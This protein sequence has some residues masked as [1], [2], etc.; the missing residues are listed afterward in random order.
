MIRLSLIGRSGLVNSAD[1][2][3]HELRHEAKE[4]AQAAIEA[5]S[6]EL[7]KCQIVEADWQ[8]RVSR[9]LAAAYLLEEDPRWQSGFDGDAQLWRQAR[10]VV[11][12]AVNENGRFLDVG[13]AT[14]H[15]MECL[16]SW[17]LEKG[18]HLEMYGLEL[19]PDLAAVARR[20]LPGWADR[21]FEGNVIDWHAP[22]RFRYVRTGLEY[23]PPG[24]ESFLVER[25]LQDVV[26]PNGR[27]I[28]G[29]LGP[30]GLQPAVAVMASAGQAQPRV[31]EAT[32]RNGKTRYVLC[33][34]KTWAGS[35]AT[36]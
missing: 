20:R 7:E 23:V 1:S 3:A 25:L 4:A 5:A 18:I 36:A 27:L 22:R 8:K 13:C 29:P 9:A 16:S 10:E 14:G 24:R 28:V 2:P 21:I 35:A 33:V 12:A 11:L 19:D 34:E 26:E 15:L 31:H 32:D 17:A 30:D 6:I